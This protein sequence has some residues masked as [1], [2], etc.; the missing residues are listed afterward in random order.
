MQDDGIGPKKSPNQANQDQIKD[1][2]KQSPIS[3]S[4]RESVFL[5]LPNPNPVFFDQRKLET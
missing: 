3:T 4:L 2:G 1:E 5:A